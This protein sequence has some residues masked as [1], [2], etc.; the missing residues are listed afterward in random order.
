LFENLEIKKILSLNQL[1]KW[2][3]IRYI[4]VGVLSAILELL[5]LIFLVEVGR[6]SYLR[7]NVFAFF[8][9]QIINYVLSGYWV[10]QTKGNKKRIEFP[11]FMVFVILGFLINQVGLWFFVEKMEIKYEVSKVIAIT[12][13]VIWNFVTRRLIVFKK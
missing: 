8:F 10:F 9:V 13:V 3:F 1:L 2:Q 4:I 5:L 7:G 12:L 6:I 11:V